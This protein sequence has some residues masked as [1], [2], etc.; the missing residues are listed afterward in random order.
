MPLILRKH[1]ADGSLLVLWEITESEAE[2]EAYCTEGEVS[3]ASQ[4]RSSA[5]RLQFL[6]WRALLHN[7]LPEATVSYNSEGAPQLLNP[8]PTPYCHISV[9]HSKGFSAML[10]SQVRCGVDIE[11][12]TRDLSRAQSRFVREG[13][14]SLSKTVRP[15]ELFPAVVWCAK[16]ALYKWARTP[17]V[18]FLQQIQLHEYPD[19]GT[20][21][22]EAHPTDEETPSNK[23]TLWG[24][25]HLPDEPSKSTLLRYFQHQ[26]LCVVYTCLR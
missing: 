17:G 3:W 8:T 24:E 7:E 15:S 6:S 10:L 5:H 20:L 19:P 11:E 2:L 12:Y 23:G 25:V 9:S 16:E 1:N 21:R 14:A 26:T 22:G 4:R 13:E 18:D